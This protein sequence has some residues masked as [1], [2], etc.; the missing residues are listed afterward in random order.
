MEGGSRLSDESKADVSK[1]RNFDIRCS[2]TFV[3][4]RRCIC[5]YSL[6]AK[7][8]YTRVTISNI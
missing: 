3:E 1:D 4:W 7:T 2:D 8:T 5:K 6:E